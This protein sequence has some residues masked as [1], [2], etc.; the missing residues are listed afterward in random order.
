MRKTLKTSGKPGRQCLFHDPLL[1]PA[2]LAVTVGWHRTVMAVC[3]HVCG[4][5][6]GV[7]AGASA[8]VCVRAPVRACAR[9]VFAIYNNI[10]TC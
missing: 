7:R 3:I 1:S 8:R 4:G 10:D 2:E 9:E 5:C 6:A